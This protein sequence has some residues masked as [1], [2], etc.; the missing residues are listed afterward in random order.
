MVTYAGLIE[1]VP[2]TELGFGMRTGDV[3]RSTQYEEGPWFYK[4][5]SL[6]YMIY[7]AGGVQEH[8]AY[9]TSVGPTGPW[10]FQDTLM[11]IIRKGGAFTNHPGIIDY[12][13]RSFFF[14]HNGALP[15]GGGF[16]RSVC[17]DEFS[18]SAD[19]NIPVIQNTA[20]GVLQPVRNLNPF[21]HQE[22]E[23]IAWERGVKTVTDQLA[24]N[25]IYITPETDAAYTKIRN[26]DFKKG[27]RRFQAGILPKDG[28]MFELRL[29]SLSSKLLGS[30]A[31]KANRIAPKMVV[32]KSVISKV[33]GIHD[34]YIVFKG[35]G[36][37]SLGL[38]WWKFNK[39]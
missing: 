36:S 15:G 28:G 18:Y 30:C 7:P 3:K 26:I 2:L 16:D 38:D 33:Q 37:N 22:A 9:S 11:R 10:H 29:D 23:T 31:L 21:V 5:N 39:N 27:A 19:G 17:V 20:T 12:H 4:R 32:I 8:I 25:H 14:Y 34:M 1:K 24:S 35:N 13:G 6:Y